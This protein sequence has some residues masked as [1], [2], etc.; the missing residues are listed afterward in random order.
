MVFGP[1]N[2][3]IWVLGTLWE[4]MLPSCVDVPELVEVFVILSCFR[5]AEK[6]STQGFLYSSFGVCYVVLAREYSIIP[7]KEPHRRAW[8]DTKPDLRVGAEGFKD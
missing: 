2:P 1:Q 3:F 8:V 6:D 5:V 4:G 7:Q